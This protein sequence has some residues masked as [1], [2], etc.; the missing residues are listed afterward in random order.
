M[1][2][3]IKLAMNIF[4]GCRNNF[5]QDCFN[6]PLLDDDY[7][8]ESYFTNYIKMNGELNKLR[9][10]LPDNLKRNIIAE[11]YQKMTSQELGFCYYSLNRNKNMLQI[12]DANNYECPAR[13]FI[14]QE[15]SKRSD[16]DQFAFIRTIS[17][18]PCESVMGVLAS[19]INLL[20]HKSRIDII[21]FIYLLDFQSTDKSFM[22]KLYIDI[23]D[24]A[25]VIRLMILD[26]KMSHQELEYFENYYYKY[27]NN[28]TRLR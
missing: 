10:H 15:L 11:I 23:L 7:I 22:H 17:M 14:Y 19:F 26:D 9:V 6:H 8:F 27:W 20:A 1:R 21:N 3:F 2:N 24:S 28:K 4:S 25:E 18:L 12:M 16:D 13:E 5:Y